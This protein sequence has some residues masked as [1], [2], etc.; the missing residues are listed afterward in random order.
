MP[1]LSGSFNAKTTWLTTIPQ[2]DVAGHEVTMAAISGMQ[3]SDDPQWNNASITYWGVGDA[4]SGNGVQWGC[5]LNK[6]TDGDYDRGTFEARIRTM[7]DKMLIEGKWAI[8]GGTGKY[9]GATG[10]GAFRSRMLSPTEVECK[11]EG[12]YQ[13]AEV[14]RGAGH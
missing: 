8:T 13:I 3:K 6:H 10:G 12:E 7:G 4:I 11:W 5:Y 2:G 14:G 1:K 9:N